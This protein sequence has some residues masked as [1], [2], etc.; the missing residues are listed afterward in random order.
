V[1]MMNDDEDTDCTQMYALRKSEGFITYLTIPYLCS[2]ITCLG[3][4]TY[5]TTR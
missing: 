2:S 4:I 5:L 3:S 1:E